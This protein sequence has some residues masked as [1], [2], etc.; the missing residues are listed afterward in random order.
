MKTLSL[1]LTIIIFALLG[2]G[3]YMND[4]IERLEVKIA[5]IDTLNVKVINAESIT[6]TNAGSPDTVY[7]NNMLLSHR[8]LKGYNN[9][10]KKVNHWDYIIK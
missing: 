5:S 8:T 2:M 9:Q 6:L 10:S 4:K 3:F 1:L 7:M